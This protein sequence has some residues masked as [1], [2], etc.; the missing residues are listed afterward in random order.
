MRTIRRSLAL[1]EAQQAAIK[2]RESIVAVSIKTPVHVEKIGQWPSIADLLKP[3]TAQ[4]DAVLT[5]QQRS[6]LNKAIGL[7]A[8]D[9][10]IG[11]FVYLR[12]I[13]E[14][15]IVEAKEQ[16]QNEENWA[17]EKVHEFDSLRIREKI[18]ELSDRLPSPL[19]K[20]TTVYGILSKGVHQLDEDTCLRYFDPLLAVVMEV[21][22]EKLAAKRTADREKQTTKELDAI[23]RNLTRN[24]SG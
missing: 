2:E 10:G 23:E 3:Q 6:E 24:D 19:V 1:V 17:K 13:V 20:R 12:R 9:V 4:Y 18:K 16:A 5:A 15:W 7:H 22:E 21:L 11:A 8:H 14:Q